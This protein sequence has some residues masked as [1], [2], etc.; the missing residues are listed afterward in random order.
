MSQS[1]FTSLIGKQAK[2]DFVGAPAGL[3]VGVWLDGCGKLQVARQMSTGPSVVDE[4]TTL[5]IQP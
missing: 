4:F 1:L 3:I 5:L 2:G